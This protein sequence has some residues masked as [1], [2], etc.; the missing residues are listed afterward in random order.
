[1]QSFQGNRG[2]MDQLL[3]P[4]PSAVLTMNRNEQKS[5]K[6]KILVRS[7]QGNRGWTDQ[8]LGPR[9]SAVL[10]M[11]RNEQKWTEMNRNHQN[12]NAVFS[13]KQ[14]MD[15][16]TVRTRTLSGFNNEQKWTEMTRNHQNRNAVF[17]RKQRMDGP[18]VWNRTLGGFN[19][20]QKWT[21][22]TKTEMRSFQGSR[23]WTDQ[24]L[25]PDPWRF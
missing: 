10:T 12:R 17:S 1:M 19:N 16:P 2:W 15:G 4:R 21:E 14:R 22:I 13:R 6:T 5:P 25:D 20:E 7:F 11:N 3:G 8:L 18:T 24:L 23:G 9:P